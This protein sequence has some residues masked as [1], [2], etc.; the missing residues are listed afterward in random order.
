MNENR[1]SSRMPTGS[2]RGSGKLSASAHKKKKRALFD[3]CLKDG[4]QRAAGAPQVMALNNKCNNNA[5]ASSGNGV[6]D[7]QCGVL[8]SVSANQPRSVSETDAT[9]DEGTFTQQIEAAIDNVPDNIDLDIFEGS[10]QSNLSL[11]STS[12][13][14]QEKMSSTT[15]ENSTSLYAVATN[16]QLSKHSVGRQQPLFRMGSIDST[17]SKSSPLKTQSKSPTT[18]TAQQK[19][20]TEFMRKRAIEIRQRNSDQ[21]QTAKQLFCSEARTSSSA[22]KPSQEFKSSEQQTSTKPSHN[23][24]ANKSLERSVEGIELFTGRS[25]PRNCNVPK[26]EG[27]VFEEVLERKETKPSKHKSTENTLTQMDGFFMEKDV[28]KKNKIENENFPKDSHYFKRL[29]DL[30]EV[31][32]KKEDVWFS[33]RPEYDGWAFLVDHIDFVNAEIHVVKV[34]A[35]MKLEKTFIGNQAAKVEHTDWVLVKRHTNL[36]PNGH[37]SLQDLSTRMES[38][39]IPFHMKLSNRHLA[40]RYEDDGDNIVFYVKKGKQVSSSAPLHED[41]R[42]LD[43]FAGGGGMSVGIRKTGFFSSKS[44]KVDSDEEACKTLRANF[45]DSEVY[46]LDIRDFN[47]KYRLRELGL[48]AALILYLHLSPPCQG[49]SRVNTSGGCKDV[50]NN[51]CTLWSIETVRLFQPLFVSMENVPGC[52]D[53]KLVPRAERTKKSYLQEFV[54]GLLCDDYQIRICKRLN[55]KHFGDPQDRERV[56]VFAS[57][58]GYTLP[59][60]PSPTHGNEVHLQNCVTARE[61]LCDLEDIEPTKDGTVW[62]NNGTSVA[63]CHYKTNN[64]TKKSGESVE[65]LQPDI[66]SNTIRKKNPVMHYN[67]KRNL[68]N[69]ERARLMSFPDSYIFQGAPNKQSGQIGNAVPVH[70]ATAIANAVVESFK[71]GLYEPSS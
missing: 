47:D 69:L 37:I 58:I 61:A 5:A 48:F 12:R 36:P 18:I 9:N 1:A 20:R 62:L 66:P 63:Y 54:G 22:S 7:Q 51:N 71:H 13:L 57:K 6:S 32:F 25:E 8:E 17:Q 50:Q 70:F 65:E 30:K 41:V 2:K 64:A 38:D 4:K 39:N 59:S 21:G 45:P 56:I 42:F 16:T 11:G 26:M 31:L 33:D 44:Y 24:Q 19:A 35:F 40:L 15:D 52:L 49:Q 14:T 27:L 60:A 53:D 29:R 46:N 55:A 28:S 43:C 23:A 67:R 68:T 3:K 34:H 10:N